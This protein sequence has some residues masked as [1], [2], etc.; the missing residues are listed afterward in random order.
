MTNIPCVL[1]A[2]AANA[3]DM[4]RVIDAQGRGPN[5]FTGARKLVAPGTSGP[6]LAYL[7]HD[8]SATDVLETAWRAMSTDRDLPAIAGTWGEDG[9]ISAAD[10]QAAMEGLTVYSAGGLTETT[11]EWIAGILSG[12]GY[13]YEPEPEV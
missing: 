6:V 10:A 4:S 1:I 9:V 8:A 7:T 13:E 5:T 12:R 2:M 3:A 11:Q